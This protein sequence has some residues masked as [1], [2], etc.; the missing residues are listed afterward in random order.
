MALIKWHSKAKEHLRLIFDYYYRNA[1]AN[2][3][4]SAAETIMG[5]VDQLEEF[6]LLG[7]KD[8]LFSTADTQYYFLVVKWR[9]RT[10]KIYYLYENDICSILAI[11]DCSMNPGK[12]KEWVKE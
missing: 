12:L 2:V 6:P 8:T 9:R 7:K 10:Y 1:S 5:S 4:L 3:A 11:W